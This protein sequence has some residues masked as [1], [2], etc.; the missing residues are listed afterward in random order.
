MVASGIWPEGSFAKAQVAILASMSLAVVGV[1]GVPVWEWSSK[2][3]SA[4]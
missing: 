2:V 1:A 3:S 4:S